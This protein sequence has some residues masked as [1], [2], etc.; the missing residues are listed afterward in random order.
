MKVVDL[1]SVKTMVDKKERVINARL[2]E[3]FNV[4]PDNPSQGT[5]GEEAS[6]VVVEFQEIVRSTVVVQGE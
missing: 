1:F 6:S 2:E 4:A 5:A 3:S